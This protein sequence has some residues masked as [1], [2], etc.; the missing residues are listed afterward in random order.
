MGVNWGAN[1]HHSTTSSGSNRSRSCNNNN[2]EEND[3]LCLEL[4]LSLGRN[5][6]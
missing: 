3:M 4:V 2:R 5:P 6:V 1:M